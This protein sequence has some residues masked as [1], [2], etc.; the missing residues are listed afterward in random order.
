MW[1][2][3]WMFCDSSLKIFCAWCDQPSLA[4]SAPAARPRNAA[5]SEGRHPTGA[6]CQLDEL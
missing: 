4:G 3:A 1:I 5:S 6:A 2:W